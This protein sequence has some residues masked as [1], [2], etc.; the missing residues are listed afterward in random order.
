VTAAVVNCGDLHVAVK[1]V[2]VQVEV[3]D[4]NVRKVDVPIEV[5]KLVFERPALDFTLRS[6]GS[7]IGIRVASVALVEPLLILAFELVIEG[8]VLDAITSLEKTL[9]LV[10]V[11]LEDL[12]VV[13]QLTRFDEPGV[14]LLMPLALT[15]ILLTRIVIALP[16]MRFQQA[17]PALGQE[18]RDVAPARHPGGVDE[19]Q[20]AEVP[21][22]AVAHVQ[23]PF[24]SVSEVLA[25]HNSEGADGR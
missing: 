5:G 25:W 11:R 7:A 1:V 20:F 17:L 23:R 6:V 14:E 15:W 9:D 8:Y 19:A 3:V 2:S 4:P 16:P 24:V 12:R 13:L 10:Q 22:L 18:Y 21:E